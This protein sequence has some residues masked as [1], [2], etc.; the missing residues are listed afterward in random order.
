MSDVPPPPP[1]PPT[2]PG[3]PTPPP[4]PPPGYGYGPSGAA[5]AAGGEPTLDQP[6]YGAPLPV[7]IR[8]FFTKYATFSGRASRAEF[9]WWALVSW[10][11]NA[12]LSTFQNHRTADGSLTGL[13]ITFSTIAA[14]W[15]LAILI[16]WLAL[17]FR[18]LHDANHSGW[19]L[20]WWFLPIIGWIILLVF[21]IQGPRPEG[22]RFDK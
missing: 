22:A 11:I 5:G 8:R 9:W 4:P 21:A 7:A 15:G 6:Y 16:P 1:A 17:W 13:S 3:P 12:V 18:R 2:P 10:V 20:F 14:L 19:N